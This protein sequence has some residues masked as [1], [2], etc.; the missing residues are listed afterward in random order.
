MMLSVDESN[1]YRVHK[2]RAIRLMADKNFALKHSD[3]EG[4]EDP[5]KITNLKSATY[6]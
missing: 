5:R 1:I 6:Q 2:L 4:G 3:F